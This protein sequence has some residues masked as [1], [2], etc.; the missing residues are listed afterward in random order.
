ITSMT[1]R[2][3]RCVSHRRF[4]LPKAAFDFAVRPAMYSRSSHSGV[5]AAAA[6]FLA[7][8]LVSVTITW[9]LCYCAGALSDPPSA[10]QSEGQAPQ[11]LRRFQRVDCRGHARFDCDRAL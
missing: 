5:L 7:A 1:Y 9:P 3:A 11:S 4:K 2:P 6:V 10:L 8:A